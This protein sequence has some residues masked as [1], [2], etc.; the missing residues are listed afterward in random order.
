MAF[1][2][3]K[4]NCSWEPKGDGESGTYAYRDGELVRVGDASPTD[5]FDCFVPEGGRV[6]ENLGHKPQEIHSKRKL[7]DQL[8]RLGLRQEV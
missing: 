1:S 6:F 3:T 4:W 8:A 5:P 7:R 2:V